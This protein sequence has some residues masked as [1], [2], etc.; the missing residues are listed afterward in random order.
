MILSKPLSVTLF[1][2]LIVQTSPISVASATENESDDVNTTEINL[3]RVVHFAAPNG[4]PVTLAAGRYSVEKRDAES[5]EIV[6]EEGES[7]VIAAA[8]SEHDETLA[9]SQALSVPIGKDSYRLLF[10]QTDGTSLE[11]AGTYSGVVTRGAATTID[12]QQVSSAYEDWLQSEDVQLRAVRLAY[13]PRPKVAETWQ[14]RMERQSAG[15]ITST[16]LR[17]AIGKTFAG[18]TVTANSCGGSWSERKT[19]INIPEAPFYKVEAGPNRLHHDFTGGERE[20]SQWTTHRGPVRRYSIRVCID[21]W[22]LKEKQGQVASGLLEV[23][24]SFGESTITTRAIDY[25]K[26]IYQTWHSR[27]NWNDERA[28]YVTPNFLTYPVLV[29]TLK[30]SF[31]G[32]KITVAVDNV[33]WDNRLNKYDIYGTSRVLPTEPNKVR[34]YKLSSLNVLL[35]RY[36]AIFDNPAVRTRLSNELTQALLANSYVNRITGIDS[37][38]SGGSVITVTYQ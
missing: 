6:A 34:D 28:V 26:S 35:G 19:T 11:A 38:N 33:R 30:P 7:N 13:D 25:W 5:L 37:A 24:L 16:S 8:A 10:L 4:E 29:A 23:H 9:D 20:R 21:N 14:Q 32:G 15:R 3:E 17:N 27:W 1:A 12:M 2:L 36:R 18:A 22:Q 31:S